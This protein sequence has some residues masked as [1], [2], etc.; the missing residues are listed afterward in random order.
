MS[1]Y[2]VELGSRPAARRLIGRLGL[3]IPLPQ[4]LARADGPLEE[5]PLSDLPVFIGRLRGG[6]LDRALAG[7][8]A[9]AGSVLFVD[10][11]ALETYRE[12]G[13]AW[14]RMPSPMPDVA[15]D[16]EK[17][18][19]L[20]F[21]AAGA[22]GP[23]DLKG[24]YAFFH[25]W[26]RSLRRCGRA[27][28]LVRPAHGSTDHQ[29]SAASQA[30]EGFV[31][32]LG[33]EIGKAGSTAQAVYVEKGAEDRLEPALRFL[34]SSRSAYITGQA[35]HVTASVTGGV[36]A[37][38]TRPLDGKAALVTGSARGIGAAI[39]T[40]FAREGARVIVMDRPSEDGPMSKL[41]AAIGGVMLPCD[42][43]G[44]GAGET[45]AGFIRERFGGV[46]VIVHNAGITRDK[47]LAN[48]DAA[49]WDS[50]L[51]VNLSGLM[52]L[53]GALLPLLRDGGRV[54]CV[55][56]VAGIAGNFGQTN[57]AASKAG[58]IGY[59]K[60]LA[61]ALSA[62]GI[63]VNAVA[64]GFIETQMTA[65]IPF[66]T[67]EGA[68]RLCSLAQGGLPSDVAEAVLFLSGPGG[69]CMTGSVLRVCGG[70]F[71]GA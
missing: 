67:R 21:D 54:V 29:A 45:V 43:T 7:P 15:G 5:R 14:G 2:L 11:E 63:S 34:L 60:A 24:M 42:L 4:K 12:A 30:V 51:D 52:R 19:A 31:K 50:V 37:A 58:V 27:L 35:M 38:W 69:S 16:G 1:D 9:A 49:R 18:H 47:T 6:E 10:G 66:A 23:D 61:P 36:K 71:V 39:A 48:M 44:E 3:P 70:N 22:V 62:R 25:K 17:P 57:Y 32:S 56:S 53:N 26:I 40:V 55:S 33:K 68:R 41:A 64:P 28:V 20:V 59:V 65:A 13:E 46:D 8:L